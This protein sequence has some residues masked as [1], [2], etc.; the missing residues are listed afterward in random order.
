[1]AKR[2]VYANAC[3]TIT[4]QLPTTVSGICTADPSLAL[5]SLAANLA[6]TALQQLLALN[7]GNLVA[8]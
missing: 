1:M 8:R 4:I 3:A 6:G 7:G 2:A 5:C